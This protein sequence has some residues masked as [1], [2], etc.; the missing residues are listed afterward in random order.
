MVSERTAI[1]ALMLVVSLLTA[2]SPRLY[3][4]ETLALDHRDLDQFEIRYQNFDGCLLKRDVPVGY[5][6]Q[7]PQYR[8]T[9]DVHFGDTGHPASIDLGL[10]GQGA[11]S[12]SFP[13]LSIAPARTETEEGVRY[14]IAADNVRNRSFVLHVLR[15]GGQ[16]G[17]ETVRIERKSCRALGLGNDS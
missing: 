15:D 16:L 2:C 4:R 12:A 6:L 1:S 11:L 17:I 9:L 7:R 5:R 14:R 8:M 3:Q 13:D 10:I